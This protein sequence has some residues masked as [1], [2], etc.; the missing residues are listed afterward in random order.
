MVPV[1]KR[2]GPPGLQEREVGSFRTLTQ[3]CWPY[4]LTGKAAVSGVRDGPEV[5]YVKA[6]PRPPPRSPLSMVH[7]PIR[8]QLAAGQR[9]PGGDALP[10]GQGATL[11]SW[12]DVPLQIPAHDA[13]P[14]LEGAGC[15]QQ[16]TT[17]IR[18]VRALLPPDTS[19]FYGVAGLGRGPR[20]GTWGHSPYWLI[21]Q[22]YIVWDSGLVHPAK[23]V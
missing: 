17:L 13:R 22:M 4:M 16:P 3:L 10:Q 5:G 7:A 2:T 21:T 15:S 1:E 23:V 20:T 11:L 8:A 9:G 12:W 6:G 19:I 14:G 18:G